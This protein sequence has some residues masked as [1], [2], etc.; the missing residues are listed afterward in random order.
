MEVLSL[1]SGSLDELSWL[2]DSII[3]LTR[4][5]S[6]KILLDNIMVGS[7]LIE[8]HLASVVFFCVFDLVWFVLHSVEALHLVL[9]HSELLA[10]Y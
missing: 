4:G 9:S 8:F 1:L 10:S 2:L 3:D 7:D 5:L 6:S